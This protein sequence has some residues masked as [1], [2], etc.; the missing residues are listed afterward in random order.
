MIVILTV[1]KTFLGRGKS[2]V[3][4]GIRI[5]GMFRATE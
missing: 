3:L 4:R 2:S 5:C 1:H